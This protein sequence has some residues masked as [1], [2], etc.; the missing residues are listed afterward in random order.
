[1]SF[2]ALL[3]NK[4]E[5]G[6]FSSTVSTIADSD[7]PAGDVLV[8]VDWS[9][10]NFKDGLIITGKGRLVKSYPHVAG[11]DFAGRV[12]ESA[13]ARYK[14][15]QAVVL[16][17]WRVGEVH[18]GGYA[19]RARV[20]GDWLVPLPDAMTPRTAM[21]LGTAGFTAKI[22]ISRLVANGLTPDK[23]EVLVTG[24]GGGVGTLAV[25]M[26]AKLGYSV[27]AVTG[28]AEM[29]DQLKKLGAETILTRAELEEDS[30]RVLDSERWAGVIDTVAGPM[31]ANV[32]KQVKYDGAVAAIGLAGGMS[33]PGS[34]VPFLLRGITLF[35]IDSVM[36]SYEARVAAW[37]ELSTLFAPDDYEPMVHEIGLADIPAQAKNI[38]EGK[39]AGRVLV[40]VRK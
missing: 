2:R 33:W 19:E 6:A 30:G 31:L 1:M 32:L 25:M 15:G 40:D 37:N 21:M 39:V 8:D 18:W 36:Q 28:R 13:D 22:A 29:G 35:G 11:I 23:G 26:L 9:G 14:P 3:T 5:Q 20:S 7:L 34:I 38:L 12:V 27:A 17:G 4:S 24:A 16:T 10:L